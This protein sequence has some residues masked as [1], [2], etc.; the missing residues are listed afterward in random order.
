MDTVVDIKDVSFAY[1]G[2]AAL[3]RV[4]LSIS[5][6]E[7]VCVVGPNGGGK[8]TLLKLILGL[9]KPRTGT[10]SV[11]GQPP[12]RVR[13]RVGYVSQQML[14][15]MAFP[16]NVMD[17]VLMGR[18]GRGP[19]L[20]PFGAADRRA[21]HRALEEVD[22]DALHGRPFSDLSGGQRQRALIARALASE[23]E[24]LLLDEPT[25]G[26]DAAVERQFYELLAT[27]NARMTLVVVSHD[28][29][30][31]SHF[32]NRVVCVR[33]EVQTHD[34]TEADEESLGRL[35]GMNMRVVRHD[36]DW[37]GGP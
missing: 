29:W 32:V 16:I 31:V 20:G 11:F 36:H 12:E 10:V 28:L 37:Q 9:L 34:T 35:C 13:D 2:E 25:A 14:A 27:M 7:F 33:R 24:M 18:L 3:E 5:E 8:S 21:A 30:F 17:V 22:I 26:L 6:R 4:N 15:D 19:H 1:N 23:P